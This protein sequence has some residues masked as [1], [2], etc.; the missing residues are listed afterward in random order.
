MKFDVSKV[1]TS[2]NADEVKVGSNGHAKTNIP[3]FI[4]Q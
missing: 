3:Q 4:T 2:V 1:Y